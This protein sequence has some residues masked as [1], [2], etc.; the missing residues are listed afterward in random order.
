M[1]K[2]NKK[3]E[4]ELKKIYMRVFDTIKIGQEDSYY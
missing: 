2:V 4:I 3:K 1:K